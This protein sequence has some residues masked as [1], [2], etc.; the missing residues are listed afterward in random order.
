MSESERAG[1]ERPEEQTVA[2]A[3]DDIPKTMQAALQAITGMQRE[4]QKAIKAAQWRAFWVRLFAAA[5]II[6]LAAAVTLII[7]VLHGRM[8]NHEVQAEANSIRA[9]AISSCQAANTA[10]ATNQKIWDGFLNLLLTNPNIA[11]TKSA[12][13]ADVAKLGLTPA[14]QQMFTD[15]IDAEYTATPST[16]A[17]IKAFETYISEHEKAQDCQTLYGQSYESL[18]G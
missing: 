15:L 17:I 8:L 3:G 1:S 10:R 16:L 5:S 12:L 7:V 2:P 13:L 18:D 9:G 4:L 11:K 14:E 6:A